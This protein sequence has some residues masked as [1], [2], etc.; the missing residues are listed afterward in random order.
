VNWILALSRSIDL[1]WRRGVDG[2]IEGL[3][4]RACGGRGGE[5]AEGKGKEERGYAERGKA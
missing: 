5:I 4:G 2:W 1:Q 3:C